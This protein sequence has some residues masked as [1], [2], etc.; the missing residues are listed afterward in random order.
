L[1]NPTLDEVIQAIFNAL[2]AAQLLQIIEEKRAEKEGNI[3]AHYIE[4]KM[5]ILSEEL[6]IPLYRLSTIYH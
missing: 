3:Q 4:R 2:Y 1:E 6:L 5:R